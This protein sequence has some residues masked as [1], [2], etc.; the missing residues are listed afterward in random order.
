MRKLVIVLVVLAMVGTAHAAIITEAGEG[1]LQMTLTY[2]G[3]GNATLTNVSGSALNVDLYEIWSTGGNLDPVN[4]LSINDAVIADVVGVMGALGAGAL[5][6]GELSATV[7]LLA[8]GNLSGSALFQDGAAWSIGQP[9]DPGTAIGDLTFYYTKPGVAGDKFLG[10]IVP[11]PATL[12]LL[13]LGGLLAL[14]RRRRR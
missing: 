7:N 4:W 5:S 10:N 11:E 14:V 9:I 6:F 1:A 12:A 3:S 2:D 13:S 8:D